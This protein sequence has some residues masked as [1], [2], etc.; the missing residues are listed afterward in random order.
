MNPETNE[1]TTNAGD[2]RNT[3]QQI[4]DEVGVSSNYQLIGQPRAPITVFMRGILN[5]LENKHTLIF[6]MSYLFQ[7]L[8]NFSLLG[9][10]ER[11]LLLL[12]R[13]PL[14]AAKYSVRIFPGTDSSVKPM[15]KLLAQVR[16]N[17]HHF[18]TILY[19]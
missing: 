11:Y 9:V 15:M 3:S 18:D 12:L 14:R 5:F 6:N 13:V 1:T 4:D 16:G 7:L 8:H 2:P 17:L 19:M 10:E